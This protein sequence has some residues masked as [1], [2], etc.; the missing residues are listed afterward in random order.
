MCLQHSVLQEEKPN[1]EKDWGGG[2]QDSELKVHMSTYNDTS[3][4]EQMTTVHSF[5]FCIEAMELKLKAEM[6]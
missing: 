3:K 1:S 4:D 2:I 6:L 5:Q